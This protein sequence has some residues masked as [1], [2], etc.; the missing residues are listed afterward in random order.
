MKRTHLA[1][2][3]LALIGFLASL[4]AHLLALAGISLGEHSPIVAWLPYGAMAVLVP[5]AFLS[6]LAFKARP[7]WADLNEVF[8][9]WIILIELVVFAYSLHGLVA[10]SH[11]SGGGHAMVK[12]GAYVLLEHGKL[13]RALSLDEYARLRSLEVQSFSSFWMVFYFRPLAYFFFKD[14]GKENGRG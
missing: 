11:A 10:S 1:F 9:V 7:T 2:G 8:P 13:I 12:D 4:S 5:Y 3:G 14:E 6:G